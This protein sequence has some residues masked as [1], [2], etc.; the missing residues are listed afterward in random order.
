MKIRVLSDLHH[1]GQNVFKYVEQDED[2]VV[3]AGDISRGITGVTWARRT[4]NRPIIYVPGNHEYDE[5]DI[6][7]LRKE[8]RSL[9][10]R[11]FPDCHVLINRW[12]IIDGVQFV[13]TTLFPDYTYFGEE[14]QAECA[15]LSSRAISDFTCQLRKGRFI[16][17]QLH[18]RY[19]RVS[20]RFLQRALRVPATTRILVTHYCAQWSVAPKFRNDPVTAGYAVPL[21]NEIVQ[22]FDR[23][24]HGHT[25][26]FF[27]YKIGNTR[28]ICNPRGF[29]SE[30]NGFVHNFV[31]EV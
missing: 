9:N 8:F 29:C 25:H 16:T 6:P 14:H 19:N 28:I 10:R 20:K 30:S 21:P 5:H 15:R 27:N 17:P 23:W 3:L 18:A 1:A 12:V 24:Y 31:D 7:V 4:I 22:G 2:V 26:E 13:G 11:H